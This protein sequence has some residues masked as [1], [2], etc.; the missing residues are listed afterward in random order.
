MFTS[1]L[2]KFFWFLQMFLLQFSPL[3]KVLAL[4]WSSCSCPTFPRDSF[5]AAARWLTSR[6]PPPR[7]VRQRAACTIKSRGP[8]RIAPSGAPR[9]CHTTMLK[10]TF[11]FLFLSLSFLLSHSL[12]V[13]V[14]LPTLERLIVTL[15]VYCRMVAG[16]SPRATAAFISRAPSMWTD[17][18][19]LSAKARTLKIWIMLANI[20]DIFFLVQFKF[21]KRRLCWGRF[22]LVK[23]SVVRAQ[24]WYKFSYDTIS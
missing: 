20:E 14:C 4:Q 15:S 17:S 11:F 24:L 6:I 8:A 9:A 2:F 13:C 5:P 23:S 19:C 12:C 21:R 3:A 22:K 16:G 1:A 18:P 10:I 7:A